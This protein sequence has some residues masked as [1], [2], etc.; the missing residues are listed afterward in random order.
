MRKI[1]YI[2]I[3]IIVIIILIVL[4][5]NDGWYI[6]KI[7]KKILS[8]LRLVE[9]YTDIKF[10]TETIVDKIEYKK[11]SPDILNDEY[12][13]ATLSISANKINSLF[14]EEY[15]DYDPSHAYGAP[16]NSDTQKIDYSCVMYNTVR[17][18]NSKT[19]RTI[20]FTVMKPE[21]EIS[22]VHISIDKLGWYLWNCWQLGG[23]D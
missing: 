22:K 20:L 9:Y 3:F 7:Q 1:K 16:P 6:Y 8:P 15:R 13:E 4:L 14:K 11:D 18:W 17:R 19:Q 12:C 10:P 23:M 21:N 2:A 5:Y